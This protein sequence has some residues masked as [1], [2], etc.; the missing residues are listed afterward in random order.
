MGWTHGITKESKMTDRLETIRALAAALALGILA[1]TE[2]QVRK[3]TALAEQIAASMSEAEI[4]AA[5]RLAHGQ[6][7]MYISERS[8][9]CRR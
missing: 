4:L 2:E 6:A 1:E 3:A 9:K 5:K 8:A 7:K